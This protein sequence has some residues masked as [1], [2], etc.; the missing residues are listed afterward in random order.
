[1]VLNGGREDSMHLCGV[2]SGR[3]GTISYACTLNEDNQVRQSGGD[4][5][6]LICLPKTILLISYLAKSPKTL[7][8]L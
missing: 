1:M 2:E 5:A 3:C 7:I 6:K 8:A 4:G